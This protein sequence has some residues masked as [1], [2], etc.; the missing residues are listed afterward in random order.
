MSR[1]LSLHEQLTGSIELNVLRHA[2]YELEGARRELR[3]AEE[4]Y[5]IALIDAHDVGLTYAQIA[6]VLGISTPAAAQQGRRARA[7]QGAQA[8]SGVA[9]S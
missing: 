3:D 9:S 5:R 7:V 4:R 1:A 8:A 2:V 6:Q